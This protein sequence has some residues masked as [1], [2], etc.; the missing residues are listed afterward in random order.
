M[1]FIVIKIVTNH[2]LPVSFSKSGPTHQCCT[3]IC[4]D[5]ASRGNPKNQ[6][7]LAQ[8]QTTIRHVSQW[9]LGFNMAVSG[10]QG[11]LTACSQFYPLF[12]RRWTHSY[13]RKTSTSLSSGSDKESY[14]LTRSYATGTHYPAPSF[15]NYAY[16]CSI[17]ARVFE[18][19][20]LDSPV[21][22]NCSVCSL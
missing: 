22:R 19:W 21:S 16:Q 8:N 17:D 4:S 6:T 13:S 7:L 1:L 9:N 20:I 14:R 10:T 12:C 15:K 3:L 18:K 11:Q 2:S 5:L